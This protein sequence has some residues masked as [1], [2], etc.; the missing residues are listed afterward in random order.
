MCNAVRGNYEKL[1]NYAFYIL[2]KK[3]YTSAE[4]VKKCRQYMKRRDMHDEAALEKVLDR[5]IELKYLDDDQY[6]KDYI[7]ERVRFKPK[8]EYALVRELKLKGIPNELSK[9]ILEE[10]PIDEFE[11]AMQALSKKE[12]IWDKFPAPKKKEK[13]YRFLSARGFSPNTIYKIV[14]K[15]YNLRTEVE[16]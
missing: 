14:D 4:L 15:R 7:A 9:K 8:G 3:R 13:A 11:M 5:L 16:S 12:K 6:A 2:A 1:L 10:S